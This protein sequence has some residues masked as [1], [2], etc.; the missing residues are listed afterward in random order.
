MTLLL[1]DDMLSV[2][3][4]ETVKPIISGYLRGRYMCPFTG[5]KKH[6]LIHHAVWEHYQGSR[7]KGYHI[8]H[9]DGNRLNNQSINLEEMRA[10]EHMRLSNLGVKKPNSGKGAKT[11]EHRNNIS[12]GLKKYKRTPEHQAN[13]NAARW[14]KQKGA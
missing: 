10:D 7:K 1:D 6:G 8:H 5:R 2:I 9:I 13:L 12:N 11:A 14:N 4:I 3:D